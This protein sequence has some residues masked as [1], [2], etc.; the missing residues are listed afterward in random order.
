MVQSDCRNSWADRLFYNISGI[1]F[2]ADPALKDGVLAPSLPEL[3]KG[4][5]SENFKKPAVYVI[6][7]YVL[8]D[9][10]EVVN[11]A[12]LTDELRINLDAFPERIDMGRGENASLET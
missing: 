9:R 1:Q 7:I 4:H 11:H 6:L 3:Q 8:F 10:L 12:L 2:S 5:H